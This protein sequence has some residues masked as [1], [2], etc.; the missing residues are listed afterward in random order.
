MGNACGCFSQDQREG[1]NLPSA[2]NKNEPCKLN[3]LNDSLSSDMNH[4][5]IEGQMKSQPHVKGNLDRSTIEESM[6]TSNLAA[7]TMHPGDLSG[8]MMSNNTY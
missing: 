4:K 7:S 1:G 8:S 6:S 3:A 5:G 2:A